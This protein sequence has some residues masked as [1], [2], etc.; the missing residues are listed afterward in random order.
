MGLLGILLLGVF[1]MFMYRRGR[2]ARNKTEVTADENIGSGSSLKDAHLARAELGNESVEP[3]MA[4]AGPGDGSRELDGGELES[5]QQAVELD[6]NTYP[7][8]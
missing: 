8:R 4:E 3:V 7:G 2:S 5:R 1:G 6:A